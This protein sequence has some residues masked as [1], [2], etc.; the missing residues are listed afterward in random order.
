MVVTVF[1]S[2]LLTG[3]CGGRTEGPDRGDGLADFASEIAGILAEIDLAHLTLADPQLSALSADE[4][5]ARYR[6][7][8]EE[9]RLALNRVNTFSVPPEA[10]EAR[11]LF[12][13]LLIAERDI[14]V[15][16][17][18]YART[19]Q[20]LHR[21]LANELLIDTSVSRQ[22]AVGNLRGVLANAG[23][24]PAALGLNPFVEAGTPT[25]SPVSRDIT[26]MLR[27]STPVVPSPTSSPEPSPTSSPPPTP[28]APALPIPLTD[29]PVSP[30]PTLTPTLTAT[31][32]A[33]PTATATPTPPRAPTA[34][35]T[36][37]PTPTPTLTVAPTVTRTPS[38]SPTMTPV[39]SGGDLIVIRFP[40][41]K[42]NP[43]FLAH[44]TVHVEPRT[45]AAVKYPFAGGDS[46]ELT[47]S[48]G[49]EKG[50]GELGLSYF[51]S[52]DSGRLLEFADFEGLW[53]GETTIP[54]DGT[55]GFYFDNADGDV[56]LTVHL[57]ITY[58]TAAPGSKLPG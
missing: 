9:M 51:E 35:P 3:V 56:R 34:T 17:V 21:V 33:S 2:V 20:E 26:A 6:D 29:A 41:R 13:A 25:A 46:L 52:S 32:T 22:V 44:W 12:G 30:T 10:Q 28:T 48:A 53:N 45:R 8:E 57:L 4:Q 7:T 11:T 14:W 40:D 42:G 55:Y 37:S 39:V 49:A 47:L 54:S 1:L 50:S 23:L 19:G 27:D 31:A 36:E 18:L 38:P 15:H 58:H 5:E 16:M 43:A 24:D